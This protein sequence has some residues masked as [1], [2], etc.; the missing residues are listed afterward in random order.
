MLAQPIEI[1]LPQRFR[2]SHVGH[3]SGYVADPRTRPMGLGLDLYGLHKSGKEFPVEISLSPLH[4]EGRLL[5]TAIV[6]D[7]TDRRASE[8]ELRD[9]ALSLAHRTV[10]L[11]S[12]NRELESF[13]YSV[14]HDLRSPLRGI[15]GFSQALLEDYADVVD[16]RGKRF[17]THVR[18]AAQEMGRLIDDLLHLSRVSRGDLRREDTDL[19]EIARSIAAHLSNDAPDREVE[20]DVVGPLVVD[21]D[22]RLIRILLENLLGNAWKF[23][24]KRACARIQ[25]G[26][27]M[28]EAYA[29]FFVRDNG[30][31]FDMRFVDKLFGPF[32]RLHSTADFEGTGI[33]LAT[34]QRIVHR[35]GGRIWAE[36]VPDQGA[37][38]RFT[39]PD[40][41]E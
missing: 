19:A 24:R 9:T 21:V 26:R 5:A 41:E 11:E 15:D 33:G 18:E 20:W 12:A 23:T 7:I 32:Q 14:S 16:E 22:P 27:E 30:A 6:R 17:L 1:L 8:R 10:E 4:T 3:R 2:E 39:L 36:G 40:G 25:V 13:A 37:V 29:V 28:G 38:F 34:A 31:G 35:H